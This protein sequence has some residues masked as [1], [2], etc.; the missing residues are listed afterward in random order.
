MCHLCSEL[1][2]DYHR[3]SERAV[4]VQ[5]TLGLLLGVHAPCTPS[6]EMQLCLMKTNVKLES[7]IKN[8]LNE[9]A[10]QTGSTHIENEKFDFQLGVQ[11][12]N[13]YQCEDQRKKLILSTF[14]EYDSFRE[15]FNFL[16]KD[17]GDSVR[18]LHRRKMAQP[19]KT[20]SCGPSSEECLIGDISSI[21]NGSKIDTSFKSEDIVVFQGNYC[22]VFSFN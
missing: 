4:Q 11:T 8:E 12:N 1:L 10:M 21:D 16:S 19:K 20:A 18:Q 3:F 14:D 6:D 9:L 2:E 17:L 15:D 22:E 7:N 13:V 5:Q